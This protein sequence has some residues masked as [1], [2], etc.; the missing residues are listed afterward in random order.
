MKKLFVSLF[1]VVSVLFFAS[2]CESE[3]D[4]K[5]AETPVGVVTV[6][7]GTGTPASKVS[8][9]TV[10]SG[11]NIET[12]LANVQILVFGQSD[13]KLYKYGNFDSVNYA[14]DDFEF[15]L[16]YGTYNVCA[17]AN[18]ASN[19]LSN[20]ATKVD[21]DAYKVHYVG[22]HEG[23][24]LTQTKL[25]QVGVSP[26]TVNSATAGTEVWLQRMCSR[27]RL[28][29]LTTALPSAYSGKTVTFVRAFL[30]NVRNG[31]ITLGGTRTSTMWSNPYGRHAVHVSDPT[32]VVGLHAVQIG[33]P[34]VFAA[35]DGP[36]TLLY[37]DSNTSI[38]YS[39]TLTPD[40]Y[41]YP[42]PNDG[43]VFEDWH[44]VTTTPSD[45]ADLATVLVVALSI[46]GTLYYYPVALDAGPGLIA[47]ESYDVSITVTN[48]GTSTPD[49]P[50]V[51]GSAAITVSVAVWD[52]G[53]EIIETL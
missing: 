39:G 34:S 21:F 44:G 19:S 51:K 5:S 12:K 25:V 50:L 49:Q 7:L 27:V 52:E 11:N 28:K 47:N 35:S 29:S 42:W 15:E 40:L 6:K 31:Y 9:I 41:F 20:I 10:R 24:S 23:S 37:A 33:T 45:S 22:A 16:P 3:S 14:S 32:C 43:T 8:D 36:V 30:Y 13:G 38:G 18:L 2:S 1:S 26:L 48:L 4:V 17:V 46:D 53:D